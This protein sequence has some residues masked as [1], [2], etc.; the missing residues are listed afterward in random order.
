MPFKGMPVCP[1]CRD[2][3]DYSRSW[4]PV[5]S[6]R[7]YVVIVCERCGL[8]HRSQSRSAFA[9]LRERESAKGGD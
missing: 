9:A 8:L 3:G 1:Q 6:T 2:R 5:T 7:R 4:K